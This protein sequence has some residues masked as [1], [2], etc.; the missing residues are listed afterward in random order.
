MSRT[1]AEG[2]PFGGAGVVSWL[3]DRGVYV[4]FAALVLFNAVFTTNFATTATF[5]N[6]LVQVSPVLI[7]SLGMA[8]VIGTEGI[9]LSV[10]SVMAL[11]AAVV[12]LYL[13]YG[14]VVA[15]LIAL[16]VGTLAGVLNGSLVAFV[17]MQPI[18]A[19]L[20]LF[21]GGRGLAQV[22][23]GG[24]LQIVSDPA[25]LALGQSDLLGIPVPVIIAAALAL[26]VG[27]VMRRTTFGRY[28]LAIGGN[29]AASYLS[30]HP[31]RG[32][33]VAV[34]AISAALATIAGILATARLSAGDPSTIGILVELD[35]IAAVVIG[36]TPLSGGKV[37]IAGTVVG[38]LVMQVIT[39]TFIMNDLPFTYAQM[40]KA[41]IILLAV[42]I[43]R[44]RGSA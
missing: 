5:F 4:A 6:L 40:L 30:G 3:R 41:V 28:V 37:S 11:A 42:Y 9:D 22:L 27:L 20:A 31:V 29:R 18:I 43:Q 10:G 7:V 16:V 35:A 25:F 26:L 13:G 32:V 19:T 17:G 24:Q 34:Y 38:A 21:V 12:P 14:P 8:L 23:V 36:G 39:A 2:R 1:V 33:L 15:I 44:G